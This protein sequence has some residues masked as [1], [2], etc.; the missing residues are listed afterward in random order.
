MEK[1]DEI[2]KVLDAESDKIIKIGVPQ[3]ITKDVNEF[4]VELIYKTDAVIFHINQKKP[5]QFSDE[6]IYKEVPKR[7]IRA[8]NP[9][10][11]KSMKV[12]IT[13]VPEMFSWAVIIRQLVNDPCLKIISE[14][15]LRA[16][17]KEFVM[18][19]SEVILR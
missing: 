1:I 12:L 19:H 6:Y 10:I 8:L 15:A 17:E 11:P 13:Y 9:I 2:K 5:M 16:L 18:P 3:F 14:A 4:T 7:I